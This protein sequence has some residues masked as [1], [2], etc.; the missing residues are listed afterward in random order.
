MPTS[1]Q[2]RI[3]LHYAGPDVDDGTMSVDDLLPVLQGFA[4]AYGKIASGRGYS[5]QHRLRVAG[6][7][8][9]SANIVLDV[10]ETVGR[11]APHLQA[12]SALSVAVLGVVTLMLQVMKVK[13]HV[14]K[15][16]FST[17][18]D[19]SMGGIAIVNSANVSLT[20]SP[21]VYTLFKEK[22]IDGDLAKIVRPL[23]PGQVDCSSIIVEVGEERQE[24]SVSA[25]E[26]PYFDVDSTVTTNTAEMWLTGMI[27]SMTKSTNS[28]HIYLQDGTRV[29]YRLVNEHPEQF[30]GVFQH[31]G[32]VKI[33]C[34]AQ[35]DENLRPTNL[36]VREI[37]P[38][39]RTLA[40]DLPA[41]PSSNDESRDED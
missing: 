13:K 22:T 19:S 18:I 37:V 33:R 25:S 2:I 31:S 8:K 10:W 27:N 23:E 17:K 9:G 6:I 7:Q 30:Y 29:H 21:D 39:Q 24:E 38:L 12:V 28:G 14:K 36:E 15:Q 3:T 20:I 4:S 16:P 11:N 32:P 40:F 34:I 41:A 5:T 35:L 1:E 26:R